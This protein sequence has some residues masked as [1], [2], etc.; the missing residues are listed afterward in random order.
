MVMHAKLQTGLTGDR[1]KPGFDSEADHVR[2]HGMMACEGH[3]L[4]DGFKSMPLGGFVRESGLNLANGDLYV[5][6]VQKEKSV[7]DILAGCWRDGRFA[8]TI[9]VYAGGTE[10]VPLAFELERL[11]QGGILPIDLVS[12]HAEGRFEVVRNAFEEQRDELRAWCVQYAQAVEA[13]LLG[14]PM[15][16]A[17]YARRTYGRYA[18]LLPS[19]FN[20]LLYGEEIA[21]E[22]SQLRRSDLKQYL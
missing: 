4:F 1:L 19:Q 18:R 21:R 14:K 15:V 9:G 12:L 7:L 8:S 10:E 3:L 20:S 2:K 11:F 5:G 17:D 6:G 16:E 13:S 22:L